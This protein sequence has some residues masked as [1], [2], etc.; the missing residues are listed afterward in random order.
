MN[1][2]PK[3]HRLDAVTPAQ[4]DQLC[5]VLI[6]C[7][8]DGASISFMLPMTRDKA[9]RFWRGIAEGVA[10]NERVLLVAQNEEG[11]IIG[12]VQV[13]LAQPENQPHRADISK[14]IVH[15]SARKKGIAAALMVAAEA[16]ALREGKTVLVLDTASDDAE[17]IYRKLGWQECGV[18]PDYALLPGGELCATTYFYKQLARD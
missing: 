6:D 1:Q 7:V 12:S 8:E 9:E 5:N 18:I 3:I 2:P 10:N 11:E 13:V 17:R 14:M 4:I 15:R 16:H